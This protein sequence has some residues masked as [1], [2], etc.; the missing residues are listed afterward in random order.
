MAD[1]AENHPLSNRR[2]KSSD[3]PNGG[4]T[5]I[6]PIANSG[7]SEAIK[8]G[9]RIYQLMVDSVRDYVII[10]LDPAGYIASWNQGAQRI[11][12][13]D[14]DEII[15]RHFSVLYTEDATS[16]GHPQHEL[17][18]ATREG[19]FEEEGWRVRKDGSTFWANVVITA[20]R[21]EQGELIGFA[22]VTR[23]LT[24]RRN[25]EQRAL[26]DAR[27][28]A[29][30]ES[31]NAAKA[32][33]LT[34]MSHELRTP[35]NAIGGYTE[36][37]SLGLGGPITAEQV[38]Y[39][40]RIRQSQQHLMGIISDLLNFSRIEAGHLTYDIGP[41]PLIQV[42]EAVVP[43]VETQAKAKG[44]SLIIDPTERDCI[45]LADRAK[46]DQILLNLLSNATKFTNRGGSVIIRCQTGEK[47]ASIQITDTGVGIH[48][49]KIEAIFEPFVQLGRSLSSA[50]EGTGLGLAI[51]RDLARAMNGNLSVVSKVGVGSTFTL[52]LPRP[53]IPRGDLKNRRPKPG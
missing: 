37:L 11:K 12:G 31:A 21:D 43:L 3:L 27:R 48:E 38:D 13:Y 7:L 32:E 41:T 17:E 45:A 22:K 14:A 42:I 47:T 20:V 4:P 29:E 16:I 9:G 39:L 24:E 15:G 6:T 44:V 25:A 26:A 30:A 23:D 19:R 40:E 52:T 8:H 46:A 34:A 50:H 18:V 53:L 5:P 51:S 36:L 2:P 49:D 33:F 28:L 35:L 1:K 10:M